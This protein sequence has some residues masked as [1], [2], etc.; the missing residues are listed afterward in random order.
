MQSCDV[1]PHDCSTAAA[2]HDRSRGN[3]PLV[4]VHSWRLSQPCD[5]HLWPFDL[6]ASA[7]RSPATKYIGLP[8]LVLIAQVV[9]LL[10]DGHSHR[11]KNTHTSATTGVDG[12]SSLV[13]MVRAIRPHSHQLFKRKKK[14]NTHTK[15]TAKPACYIARP[16]PACWPAKPKPSYAPANMATT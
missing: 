7:C 2:A 14:N 11:R 5:L 13:L 15:C 8:S 3:P 4:T 1:Q 16:R 9:F 12:D 6:T 10:E